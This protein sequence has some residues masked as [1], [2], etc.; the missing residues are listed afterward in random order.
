MSERRELVGP[1]IIKMTKGRLSS[2]GQ[3]QHQQHSDYR[4]QLCAM[5]TL[6]SKQ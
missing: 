4:G 2:P 3:L 1:E 5:A 6:K